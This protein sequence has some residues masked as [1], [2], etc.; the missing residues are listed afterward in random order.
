MNEI[1]INKRKKNE[2][3]L[4][5]IIM[6]ILLCVGVWTIDILQETIEEF[7]L[8]LI[9][10]SV[11]KYVSICIVWFALC[12]KYTVHGNMYICLDELR[13]TVRVLKFI[14]EIFKNLYFSVI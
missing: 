4:Y 2:T 9:L 13:V 6:V 11:K 8:A 14:L 7:L 5:N 12:I 10:N 3:K 1:Q